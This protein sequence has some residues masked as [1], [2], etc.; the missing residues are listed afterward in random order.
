MSRKIDLDQ[1]LSDY[2]RK[3]LLDRDQW[4]DLQY[5][6]EVLGEEFSPPGQLPETGPEATINA[7]GPT[8][9]TPEQ[10]AAYQEAE[11][12]GPSVDYNSLTVTELKAE[13]DDRLAET[14]ADD[15]RENLAYGARDTKDVLVAK[16]EKDD[17]IVAGK[18]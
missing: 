10:Q 16:L 11:N 15:E 14:E 7:L 18:E 8:A 13:L 3:Y 4:Q 9:L 17:E 6:A 12:S 2:D 5:N 1:P